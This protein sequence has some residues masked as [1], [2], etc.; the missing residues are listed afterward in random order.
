MP[1]PSE[2]FALSRSALVCLQGSRT[3]RVPRDIKNVD[4]DVKVVEGAIKSDY[5]IFISLLLL[6][7]LA[8]LLGC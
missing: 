4:I 8:R 2:P 3:R 5:F 6:L 7:F 1:K